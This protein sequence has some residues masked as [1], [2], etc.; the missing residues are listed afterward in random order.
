MC[1]INRL[2]FAEYL[3]IAGEIIECFPLILIAGTDVERVQTAQDVQLG[4]GQPG[5]S[6]QSDG[7]VENNRIKPTAS[8]SSSGCSTEFSTF[9]LDGIANI[10][11]KF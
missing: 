10:I 3:E 11:K 1:F 5:Q 7:I 4:Y 2:T 9:F 6:I 8:P